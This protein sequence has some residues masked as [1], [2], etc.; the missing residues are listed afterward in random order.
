[1]FE[2]WIHQQANLTMKFLL[3]GHL[4]ILGRKIGNSWGGGGLITFEI[5]LED[6]H[7]HILTLFH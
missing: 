2:W 7:L 4:N 1:M 5:S 6:E 3:V